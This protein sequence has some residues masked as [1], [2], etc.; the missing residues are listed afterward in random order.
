M[1]DVETP[2]DVEDVASD[3][4]DELAGDKEPE[5]GPVDGAILHIY[6]FPLK[7][8]LRLLK[9]TTPPTMGG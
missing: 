3:E 4:D 7:L 8:T 5:V 9:L 2:A 1:E 6:L